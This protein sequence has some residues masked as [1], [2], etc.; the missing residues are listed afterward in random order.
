MYSV[1]ALRLALSLQGT[2][3]SPSSEAESH[4]ALRGFMQY[5]A[6]RAV[7]WQSE[8]T[9]SAQEVTLKFQ[10]WLLARQIASLFEANIGPLLDLEETLQ[11]AQLPAATVLKAIEREYDE[12]LTNEPLLGYDMAGNA[13]VRQPAKWIHRAEAVFK[14][15]DSEGR[16]YLVSDSLTY[17][18]LALKQSAALGRDMNQEVKELLGHMKHWQ[19]Q[20]P[21]LCFK[22]YLL[23]CG[24][25]SMQAITTLQVRIKRLAKSWNTLKTQAT[26]VEESLLSCC[27]HFVHSQDPFPSILEQSIQLALPVTYPGFESLQSFLRLSLPAAVVM[28]LKSEASSEEAVAA[29]ASKYPGDLSQDLL[30]VLT[31]TIHFYIRLSRIALELLLDPES[32]LRTAKQSPSRPDMSPSRTLTPSYFR[33]TISSSLKHSQPSSRLGI[34]NS[35]LIKEESVPRVRLSLRDLQGVQAKQ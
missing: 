11:T 18:L 13:V 21:S 6:L 32:N 27:G 34:L 9:L 33:P 22:V 3:F 31:K 14:E 28:N 35:L 24:Y 16:R 15:L 23:R 10:E 7:K 5:W 30:L 25:A 20:V 19:G 1:Q 4:V 17:L 8:G 26:Q 29:L 2:D 12:W